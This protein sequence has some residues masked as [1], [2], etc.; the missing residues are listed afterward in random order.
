MKKCNYKA[1][2]FALVV[3]LS[4]RASSEELNIVNSEKIIKE[5]VGNT[6]EYEKID[7]NNGI[8]KYAGNKNGLKTKELKM[9][10]NAA[11]DI[12]LITNT[13]KNKYAFSI[14]GGGKI[15]R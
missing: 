14:V 3:L 5:T 2:I 9:M 12:T 15:K 11:V 10:N 13:E 4:I 6:K 7:I 8:F 1:G